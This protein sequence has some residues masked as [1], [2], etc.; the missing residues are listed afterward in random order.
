M[1]RAQEY[2]GNVDWETV[3]NLLVQATFNGYVR[4]LKDYRDE[5]ISFENVKEEIDRISKEL[6]EYY[7]N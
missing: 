4:G 1:S 3:Q 7:Y 2:R 6:K 5:D